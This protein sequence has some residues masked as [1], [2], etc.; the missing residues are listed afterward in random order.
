MTLQSSGPI[1]LANVQSEFGGSNPIGINEYYGVAAGVPASGTISLN[2][3]YGKSAGFTWSSQIMGRL[4][5]INRFNTYEEF[6]GVIITPGASSSP[7]TFTIRISNNGAIMQLALY[8]GGSIAQTWSSNN[9]ENTVSNYTSYFGG[10]S[11][12]FRSQ[13]LDLNS[14]GYNAS[15]NRVD[16][17][18]VPIVFEHEFDAV[19]ID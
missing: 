14:E 18:A 4:I 1:S 11:L 13:I 16:V 12:Q 15:G 5:G 10:S 7:V 3:F 9:I 2:N 19:P 8:V 17:G 6:D